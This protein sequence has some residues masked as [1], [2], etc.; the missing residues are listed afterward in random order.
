M[1][2]VVGGTT[3]TGTQTLLAS[4]LTGTASAINGSNI[5]NLPASAPVIKGGGG[6]WGATGISTG[7][8]SVSAS[9]SISGFSTGGTAYFS[10]DANGRWLNNMSIS[11]SGSGVSNVVFKCNVVK[12]SGSSEENVFQQGFY[13]S[14]DFTGNPSGNITLS[15]NYYG[16][17]EYQT[18]YFHAGAVGVYAVGV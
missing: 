1:A 15:G 10:G 11:V 17:N 4:V 12:L 13:G 18:S 6:T 2:I 16:V 5:T 8:K 14:F 9:Y 7:N 3:V